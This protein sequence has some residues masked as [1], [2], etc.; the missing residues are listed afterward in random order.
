M[1]PGRQE[2]RGAWV[3]AAPSPGGDRQPPPLQA[4][5]RIT[6]TGSS[7]SVP[8]R[9]VPAARGA[10]WPLL[11]RQGAGLFELRHARRGSDP[12]ARGGRGVVQSV[13]RIKGQRRQNG[14]LSD[15]AWAAIRGGASPER[16]RPLILGPETARTKAKSSAKCWGGVRRDRRVPVPGRIRRACRRG[17]SLAPPRAAG[18]DRVREPRLAARGASGFA[19]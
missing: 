18:A 4:G 3:D 9:P 11:R 5:V 13:G 17:G 15:A 1:G 10:G 16:E 19:G 6:G 8:V 7:A 14:C 2:L 12:V